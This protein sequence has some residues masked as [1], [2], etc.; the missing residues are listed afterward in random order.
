MLEEGAAT[1]RK[2]GSVIVI[3]EYA[4][5]KL[6]SEVTKVRNYFDTAGVARKIASFHAGSGARA[7]F[8]TV[9]R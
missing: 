1:E 7:P 4:Y 3:S 6:R 5:G 2:A 8:F 9:G